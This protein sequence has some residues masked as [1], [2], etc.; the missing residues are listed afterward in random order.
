MTAPFVFLPGWCVG[1]TPVNA[2]ASALNGSII[3]LKTEGDS[4]Q[5][6]YHSDTR[7]F[8][9]L[10]RNGTLDTTV[11]PAGTHNVRLK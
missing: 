1:R 7:A 9:V 3:D 2:A 11:L 4:L 10:D 8:A 6:T 5:L